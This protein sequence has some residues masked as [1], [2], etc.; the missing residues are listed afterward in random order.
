M[1]EK[2]EKDIRPQK[3]GT[4]YSFKKRNPKSLWFNSQSKGNLLVFNK[5]N[6]RF[7]IETT[8]LTEPFRNMYNF[9][10]VFVNCWSY[11]S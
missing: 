10:H 2:N 9:K 3:K 4:K 1:A 8:P 7:G 11:L 5:H 6:E